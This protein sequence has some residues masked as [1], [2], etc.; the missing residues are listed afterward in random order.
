MSPPQ[1]CMESEQAGTALTGKISWLGSALRQ[2]RCSASFVSTGPRVPSGTGPG[3]PHWPSCP[4]LFVYPA[5]QISPLVWEVGWGH[6]TEVCRV[7]LVEFKGKFPGGLSSHNSQRLRQELPQIG[8]PAWLG[9]SGTKA[10]EH[11]LAEAGKLRHTQV[12]LCPF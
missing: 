8:L 6:L 10:L 11:S 12:A 5:G 4:R 2:S 1:A 9:F 3:V 7:L